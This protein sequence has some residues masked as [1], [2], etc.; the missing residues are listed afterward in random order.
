MSVGGDF[1]LAINTNG[2]LWSWGD[3]NSGQLGNG[4][5]QLAD[6]TSAN[7]LTPALDNCP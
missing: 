2:T 6:G 3:N 4:S 1:S 5:G 7:R